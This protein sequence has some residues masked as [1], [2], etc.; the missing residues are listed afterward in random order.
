MRD[1]AS[2]LYGRI[3]DELQQDDLTFQFKTPESEEQHAGALA[4]TLHRQEGRGGLRIIVDRVDRQKPLRLLIDYE[5]PP[6]PQHVIERADLVHGAV[7]D[8][9]EGPWQKVLAE[10][11]LRAQCN[12][13]AGDALQYVRSHLV[14]ISEAWAESLGPQLRFAGVKLEVP[15]VRQS[16]DPLEGP[17]RSLSIEVLREDR[18]LLYVELVSQWTQLL[19]A[20]AK[21]PMDPMM[22]RRFDQPPSAYIANSHEFLE[23]QLRALAVDRQGAQ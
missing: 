18:R 1:E 23:S 21:I 20:E 12:V 10:V 6:S 17:S 22:I 13:T 3:C 4:I 15:E 11:R 16:A 19:S 9:L 2:R 8:A 7:F 5:W 14:R